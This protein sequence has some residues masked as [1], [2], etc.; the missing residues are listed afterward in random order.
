MRSHLL[1]DHLDDLVLIASLVDIGQ[2]QVARVATDTQAFQ[3]AR[4]GS[5]LE[6]RVIGRMEGKLR[7]ELAD[8]SLQRA[9]LG[10]RFRIGGGGRQREAGD[11]PCKDAEKLEM[12]HD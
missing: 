1:G 4:R 5:L 8:R 9:L 6:R 10:R 2:R 7:V 11:E 12:L 3:L